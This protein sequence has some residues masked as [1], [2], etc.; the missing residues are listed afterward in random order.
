M[1]CYGGRFEN[2]AI[3]NAI[4]QDRNYLDLPINLGR[5]YLSVNLVYDWLLKKNSKHI[6]NF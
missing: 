2:T 1:N 3:E 5:C 4:L 6:E